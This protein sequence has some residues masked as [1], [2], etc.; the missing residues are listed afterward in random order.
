LFQDA[1]NADDLD[2]LVNFYEPEGVFV[3]APGQVA[4]DP[5]SI[6][7]VLAGSWR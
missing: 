4:A 5:A 3:P 7:E 2:G 1:F 6:R